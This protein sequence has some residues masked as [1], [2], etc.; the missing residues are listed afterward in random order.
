MF[1]QD[2]QVCMQRDNECD[3]DF[4]CPGFHK[5]CPDKCR[6]RCI[7][8]VTGRII[9]LCY[10]RMLFWT[11]YVVL[12]TLNFVKHF[13]RKVHLDRYQLL[14]YYSF[15]PCFIAAFQITPF[16]CQFVILWVAY[17]NFLTLFQILRSLVR[18]QNCIK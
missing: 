17:S 15:L 12:L 2:A 3:S 16:W 18:L 6:R 10:L 5:C 7:P 1:K 11:T 8:V 13:D 4:G 14:R 9:F